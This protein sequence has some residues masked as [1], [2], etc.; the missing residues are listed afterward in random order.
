VNNPDF[1]ERFDEQAKQ[2]AGYDPLIGQNNK[3]S[4][5]RRVRG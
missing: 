3:H 1:K 4:S 5:R 2:G